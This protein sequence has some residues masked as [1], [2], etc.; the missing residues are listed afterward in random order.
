MNSNN[1]LDLYQA[2]KIKVACAISHYN[3][4]TLEQ[5]LESI[6]KMDADF[7]GTEIVSGKAP[8]CESFNAA[9]DFALESGADLMFHTA[10]D[11]IV[12]KNAL[13][14]LLRVMDV[15][16]NY[17]SVGSGYDSIWGYKKRVGI[18]IF[19]MNVLKDKFRFRNVFKQDLDL[20]ERIEEKTGKTRVYTPYEMTLAYHHLLWTPEELYLKY[21]YSLPKYD[22]SKQKVMEKFLQ[23]NLEKSPKNKTLLA[24][25]KGAELA[26]EKGLINGSKNNEEIQK[27]FIEL[28]KDLDLK[29]DEFFVDPKWYDLGLTN[30]NKLIF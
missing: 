21:R 25:L 2:G 26:K 27:E 11:V 4:K 16:E 17:L 10:A 6:K 28:T 8:M 1:A 5:C 29:G 24:G 9:L 18:W 7:I 15:E 20:C 12:E 19:N 23:D 30:P 3:E 14:E 22:P 13:S